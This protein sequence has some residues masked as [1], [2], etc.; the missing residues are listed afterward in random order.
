M[1]VKSVRGIVK[2]IPKGSVLSYGDVAKRAGVPGAARAVGM[3]MSHNDDKSIPCHR[4]VLADGSL[5]G[6]NSIQGDSKM[7]LLKKEGVKFTPSG[8]VIGAFLF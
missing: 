5:S 4:V 7:N 3:I 6:Y 2:K 1:F 8:K